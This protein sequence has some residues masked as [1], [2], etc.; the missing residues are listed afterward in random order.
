MPTGAEKK[1][2]KKKK[3]NLIKSL[4]K[5]KSFTGKRKMSAWN[6]SPYHLVE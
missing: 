2:K 6:Y 1:N 5:K 4:P 3:I